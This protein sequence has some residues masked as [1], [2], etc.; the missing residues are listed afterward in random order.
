MRS[1]DTARS[2][3]ELLLYAL[4]RGYRGE[5][6]IIPLNP[7]FRPW[8]RAEVLSVRGQLSTEQLA[9]LLAD[10]F[11]TAEKLTRG[12]LDAF[13]WFLGGGEETRGDREEGVRCCD[14]LE[15][16]PALTAAFRRVYGID[17]TRE[18]LHWWLFRALLEDLLTTDRI[19]QVAAYRSMTLDNMSAEQR[20][21]FLRKKAR[22]ALTE[23]CA[24]TVEQRDRRLVARLR[25]AAERGKED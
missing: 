1:C 24:E 14:L 18:S 13:L 22:Y 12:H 25:A 6:G 3:R 10:C 17:L 11:P 2:R 5:E 19:E 15:D 7:D 8:A 4:P 21:Y 16:G 23:P 20:R 9:E